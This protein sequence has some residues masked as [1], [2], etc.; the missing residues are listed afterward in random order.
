MWNEI[1]EKHKGKVLG[2]L[3]GIFLSIIYIISGFW[4]MV[5]CAFLLLLSYYFGNKS[6][7][8]EPWFD[9]SKLFSWLKEKWNI[10]R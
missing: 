9:L 3:C 7:M 6:D 8:N 4:D 10:Y 5:M 2:I 1:R